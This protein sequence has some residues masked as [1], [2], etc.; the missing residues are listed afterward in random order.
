[1][2]FGSDGDE[3]GAMVEWHGPGEVGGGPAPGHVTY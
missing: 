3:A 1:V 2:S